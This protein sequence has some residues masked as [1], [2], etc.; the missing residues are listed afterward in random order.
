[1]VRAEGSRRREDDYQDFFRN[2]FYFS[3][4][5]CVMDFNDIAI[6]YKR[7][8]NCCQQNLKCFDEPLFSLGVAMTVKLN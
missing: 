1:M 7:P 4:M 8:I 5:L 6:L 2:D 3:F